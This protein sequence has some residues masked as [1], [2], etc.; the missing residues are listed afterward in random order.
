M[1]HELSE[2]ANESLRNQSN[3]LSNPNIDFDTDL[4]QPI[5][6]LIVPELQDAWLDFIKDDV[7]KYTRLVKFISKNI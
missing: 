1:P 5:M 2:A 3:N 7:L 4:F 6:E